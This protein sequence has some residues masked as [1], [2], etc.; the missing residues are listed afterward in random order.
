MQRT[1]LYITFPIFKMRRRQRFHPVGDNDDVTDADT[2]QT[3][4]DKDIHTM[5]DGEISVGM[6]KRLL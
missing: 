5:E 2:N 4:K 3:D 1:R 6:F